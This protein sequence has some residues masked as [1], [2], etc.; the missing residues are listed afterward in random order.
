MIGETVI[1][2][3]YLPPSPSDSLPSHDSTDI[4]GTVTSRPREHSSANSEDEWILVSGTPASCVQI[5]LYH[6]FKE[7]PPIDVVVSGPN[8]GRNVTAVFSLSSG[9]LGAA[10]EAALCGKRAIALSY[11]FTRGIETTAEILEETHGMA[12]RLIEYLVKNW[13]NLSDEANR[14]ELYSVNISLLAGVSKQKVLWTPV[15]QNKWARNSCFEAVEVPN[16]TAGVV[17]DADAEERIIRNAESSPEQQEASEKKS[18]TTRQTHKEFRW[19]PKFMDVYKSVEDA[20]PGSD[21]WI[22][23]QGGTRYVSDDQWSDLA[24]VCAA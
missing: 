9:T 19:A 24:N 4:I 20:G 1:P 13:D 11:A 5:G 23:Q 10:M 7:R 21:G 14:A 6:Y 12:V 16:D 3:Y 15:L 8:F 18:S 17:R 22:V 2:S